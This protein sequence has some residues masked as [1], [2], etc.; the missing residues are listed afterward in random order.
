[1][2]Q[3]ELD[4]VTGQTWWHGSRDMIA[5]FTDNPQ[6]LHFGSRAQAEMRNRAFLHEVTLRP[7]SVT[8]VTDRQDWS[9]VVR[10]SRRRQRDASVYVNRSE[11]LSLARVTALDAA[12]LLQRIDALSDARFRRAVPEAAD[13][14][15]VF[16]ADI[17]RI[18]R[19]LDHEGQTVWSRT[20]LIAPEVPGDMPGF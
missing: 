1:M 4:I 14:V 15:V 3:A 11:G 6:G 5:A 10:A 2:P 20:P 19:I 7:S 12:G 13:S 9:P 18:E 16:F 17:V 8:R